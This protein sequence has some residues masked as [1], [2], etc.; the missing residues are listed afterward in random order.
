MSETLLRE[1]LE[2]HLDTVDVPSGDVLSAIRAG[3]RQ[4]RRRTALAAG[5]SALALAVVAGTGV[6]LLS[7]DDSTVVP[8][9]SEYASLGPLDFS[10][11]ARAYADP[12]GEIHLGG[13]SFPAKDLDY[14]DTDAVATN[15]G[16]VFF[17]RGRPMLLGAD[18]NVVALV[19]G[20]LDKADDFHPTAKADSVNPWVAW[21][22]RSGG[23]ITLTV[24]DLEQGAVVRSVPV[25]CGEEPRQARSGWPATTS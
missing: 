5:G 7:G 12:G 17:D 4:R 10:K 21:A 18:G 19:Q 25:P 16:I 9:R 15:Y 23:V 13:R 6:A 11:G 22:T 20:D 3:S 24:Y 2:R 14:L 1:S 8:D